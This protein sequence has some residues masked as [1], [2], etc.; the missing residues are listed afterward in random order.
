MER[1]NTFEVQENPDGT[2]T[3][4]PTP[5]TVTQAGTPVNATNLNKI[6]DGIVNLENAYCCAFGRRCEE[7]YHSS[8]SNEN[9]HWIKF[10]D[11]TMIS[12]LIKKIPFTANQTYYGLSES[13]PEPFY[14]NDSLNIVPV[15]QVTAYSSEF[16]VSN[17][18]GLATSAGFAIS[19]AQYR[20]GVAFP[21]AL[22]SGHAI[23][24]ITI[25]GRW[26]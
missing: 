26:K 22:P 11:G 12:H 5:G 20:W 23:I 19:G 2:I 8:G 24:N 13:F 16:T 6:E 10:D 3:L 9:G 7:T 17:S 14:Y 4:I 21:V 1:P 18:N 25:I 15:V